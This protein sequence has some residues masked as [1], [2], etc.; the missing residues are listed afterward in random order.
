MMKL[1]IW[2]LTFVR[3]VI[4]I[5]W[6]VLVT[7]PLSVMVITSALLIRWRRLDDLII[8]WF[9]SWPILLIA[10]IKVE[11]SGQE[12]VAQGSKGC[13]LLFNHSS[14][15][16]IPV[17]YGYFPRTFRF[18]AK[19]ELFRVPFFGV[20]MKAVGV[21]PIDRS[22]REKVMKVYEEAEARVAAGESF[23]LAPEGT[24]SDRPEIRTFKRGPFE[25]A[26]NAGA[27]LVPV[28]L[29][30]AF[31][32][33]PRNSI[34]VNLGQW[35]RTVKMII[36]PRISTTG[37]SVEQFEIVQSKARQQMEPL[38]NLEHQKMYPT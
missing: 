30:G 31:E 19:I 12:N 8:D 4:L 6:V 2:P 15:M 29:V 5:L 7:P 23:A 17:L 27:D 18:G 34:L 33:L 25:F 36:T 1:V 37:L 20:A 21:L 10:G 16:D 26:I 3:A 35:R 11:V 32:V 14:F 38:F 9:W 22:K 13:L 28:V 24:R